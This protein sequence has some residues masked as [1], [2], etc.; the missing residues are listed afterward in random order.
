MNWNFVWR[1][2]APGQCVIAAASAARH[3]VGVADEEIDSVKVSPCKCVVAALGVVRHG[4]GVAVEVVYGAMPS[5]ST[6][7][8]VSSPPRA[9]SD[10]EKR[11]RRGYWSSVLPAQ[12][13]VAAAGVVGHSISI[14]VHFVVRKICPA[15]SMSSPPRVS[16]DMA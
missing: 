2:S 13:I 5:I 15:I 1:T 3:G 6:P 7:I 9:S 10:M 12:R 16:S 11:R 8:S 4:I 14:A